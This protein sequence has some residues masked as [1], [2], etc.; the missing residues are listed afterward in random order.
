MSK[1]ISEKGSVRVETFGLSQEQHNVVLEM[2]DKEKMSLGN[3]ELTSPDREM[4]NVWISDAHSE[5]E[6]D[7]AEFL[8]NALANE[9]E[10]Y[11]LEDC[12]LG[13]VTQ[14]IGEVAVFEI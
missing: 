10:I 14:Q 12:L 13:D 2:I 9:A 3:Y 11:T 1:L 4:V 6:E 5:G 7:Y 8:R